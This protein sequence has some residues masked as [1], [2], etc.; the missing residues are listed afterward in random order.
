MHGTVT[1]TRALVALARTEQLPFLAAAI[2]YY[3]FLSVVPLLV[4]SL[5]LAS[6]LAGDALAAELVE[7]LDAVLTSEAT[8]TVEETLLDAPGR[9]ATT[10]L[11]AVVALWG[12]LRV[13]RGLDTAFSRVYGVTGPKPLVRQIR[14]ALVVLVAIALAVTTMGLAV[15]VLSLAPETLGGALGTVGLVVALPVVF[16]PLYYVFPARDVTVREAIPGA[17]FAG[18]VWWVLGS[19]FG[20]YAARTGLT[21]LYG[22][23]GGVVLLLV[24]FYASGLVLLVGASLN[25]VLGGR[26]EDRQLQHDGPRRA[27]QRT[28]M[29]D[30]DRDESDDTGGT[31]DRNPSASDR[32]RGTDDERES[33]LESGVDAAGDGRSSDRSERAET[34]ATVTPEELERLRERVEEFEEDIEDRTLHRDEIERELEAYVRSRSRRGHARGW[35]PYLVLG[36]GTVMTVAAFVFLGGLWAILAMLVI[37][38]STLG[39]YALMVVVGLTSAAV[40]LPGR[41]AD[42]LRSLRN[43]R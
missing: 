40:G 7:T 28:T 5:G 17:V 18:L 41:I 22:V 29:S 42:R 4:V 12:S 19:V 10:A 6:T 16:F 26:V 38:L 39:L 20:I 2:A 36:Y 23:L 30:S 15:A 43:L 1:K 34:D 13:F 31:P 27:S 35:G 21:E 37:W 9:E 11:S 32:P 25:A 33:Q 14:D 3:A 8:D 24:W